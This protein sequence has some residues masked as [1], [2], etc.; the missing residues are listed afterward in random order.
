MDKAIVEYPV[1]HVA[2]PQDRV[3]KYDWSLANSALCQEV[4]RFLVE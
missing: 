1:L 4:Q 3:A 2:L